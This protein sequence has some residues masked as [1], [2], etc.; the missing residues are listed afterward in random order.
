MG[1]IPQVG[2]IPHFA[3]NGVCVRFNAKRRATLGLVWV[4]PKQ[5][6]QIA[7]K[8]ARQRTPKVQQGTFDARQRAD[9]KKPTP[10]KGRLEVVLAWLT[11]KR[12]SRL[13]K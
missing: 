9:A 11:L 2:A 5:G 8:R 3:G 1:K 7:R 6:P 4:G 10:N 12:L 13:P